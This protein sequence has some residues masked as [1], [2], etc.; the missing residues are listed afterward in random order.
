MN[1]S[2][3][4]TLRQ[5]LP[6]AFQLPWRWR[7][8][9]LRSYTNDVYLVEGGSERFVLKLYGTGWRRDSEIRY[10]IDLLRHLEHLTDRPLDLIESLDVDAA[11]RHSPTDL[12]A[13]LRARITEL[14]ERGLD[15]GPCHGDLTFDNVHTT[16]AGETVWYDFDSGGPGWRAIDLQGWALA[17]PECHADWHAFLDGYRAV[18]PLNDTDVLAAPLVWLA[19]KLWG[20]E[21]DIRRRLLAKGMPDV[22]RWLAGEAARLSA[23]ARA[24]GL[25]P[26]RCRTAVTV[27]GC[28]C[29]RNCL[30]RPRWR[31]ADR[32][33]RPNPERPRCPMRMPGGVLRSPPRSSAVRAAWSGKP[34]P[35]LR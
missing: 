18:R 28:A 10:E 27:S 20:V 22:R 30:R 23:T 31:R 34:P 8:T 21:V 24:M 14:A 9:L 26:L 12:G 3:D 13:V 32:R 16:D 11:D 5:W 6:G 33:T 15:W 4:D 17:L 2:V 29:C 1:A 7:V 35:H 25:S 19:K